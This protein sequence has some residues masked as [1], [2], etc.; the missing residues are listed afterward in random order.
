MI[1]GWGT[2]VPNTCTTFSF[3]VG[4]FSGSFQDD[5]IGEDFMPNS[6]N[7]ATVSLEVCTDCEGTVFGNKTIDLCGV[8]G[9]D[10]SSCGVKIINFTGDPETDFTGDGVFVV[11]D[12]FGDTPSLDVGV[13]G[14]LGSVISCWDIK[15]TYF[16]TNINE[17]YI[18]LDYFGIAGDSDGNGFPGSP[19]PELV[20]IGGQDIPDMVLSESLA[21]QI[22]LN[23]E[24]IFNL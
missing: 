11:N 21:I 7:S 24:G 8:C 18:G 3:D 10:N 13:P 16:F 5:G 6:S 2:V 1:S 17:L 23:Q 4:L 20:A 14:Q 22:D 12:L 9:G 19:S 15:S